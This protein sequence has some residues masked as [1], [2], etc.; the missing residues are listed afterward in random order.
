MLV[1]TAGGMGSDAKRVYQSTWGIV[2]GDL[3]VCHRSEAYTASASQLS[4]QYLI[5]YPIVA[6]KPQT[7]GIRA[8]PSAL[9]DGSV[10]SPIT[11]FITPVKICERL[12]YLPYKRFIPIFPFSNPVR[13]RLNHRQLR[14]ATCGITEGPPDD[15]ANKGP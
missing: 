8:N 2:L 13:H 6:P 10:S 12:C 9:F 4:A 5:A 3:R 11:L 7:T 1:Y 14:E 15:Q